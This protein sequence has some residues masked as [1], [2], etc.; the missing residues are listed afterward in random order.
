M[1]LPSEH[2]KEQLNIAYVTAVVAKAGATFD[3]PKQDY[4]IDG[5]IAEVRRFQDGKYHATN[6]I[7]NCQLKAT[8]NYNLKDDSVAYEMEVEA[9]NKLV[10]SEGNTYRILIVFCLPSD[11]QNWLNITE[12]QLILKKC[13]YWAFIVDVP[14]TNKRSRTIHIPRTNLFTPEAV[15]VMFDYI[16][17]GEAPNGIA[18]N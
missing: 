3:S 7:L 16:K 2:L 13:C 15:K 17:R 5:R 8:T 14:S 11:W 9:Y 6:W 4:G 12:E 1:D 10:E 18:G